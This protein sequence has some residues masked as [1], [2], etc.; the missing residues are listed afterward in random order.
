MFKTKRDAIDFVRKFCVWEQELW[1]MKEKWTPQLGAEMYAEN[2][3][4]GWMG[5]W[6]KGMETLEVYGPLQDSI[7]S[8]RI[9]GFTVKF[10]ANNMVS[11]E[12]HGVYK[13]FT[14]EE[15]IVIMTIT[16][17]INNEGKIVRLTRMASQ[18]H[19]D[20]LDSNAKAYLTMS[21]FMAVFVQ[22]WNMRT[23]GNSVVTE[24]KP[25]SVEAEGTMKEPGAKPVRI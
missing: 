11:F 20:S 18:E 23:R 14:G 8:Y 12:T 17:D 7:T 10:W 24:R 2:C 15:E 9:V 4:H 6:T 13:F 19:A 5:K 21:S 1:S 3:K 16:I 25:E 22:T